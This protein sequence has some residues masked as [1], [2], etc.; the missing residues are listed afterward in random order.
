M[1]NKKKQIE[2]IEEIE[3][4]IKSNLTEGRFA[5]AFAK[6]VAIQIAEHYQSKLPEDSI[7]LPKEE[8]EYLKN[9]Q[10]PLSP[11]VLSEKQYL[12]L[13][14]KAYFSSKEMAEKIFAEL[15]YIASIHHSDVANILAWAKDKATELGVEIKEYRWIYECLYSNLGR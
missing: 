3:T 15:F 2:E 6:K 5:S 10:M 7:V 13:S 12:E 14:H 8:F 11:I 4:I 1:G 9:N